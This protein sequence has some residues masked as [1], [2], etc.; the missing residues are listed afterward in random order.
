MI[1]PTKVDAR[2]LMKL[3]PLSSLPLRAL[4]MLAANLD[5][6]TVK[7]KTRIFEQ[8][9]TADKVFLLL[10][11]VVK[12]SWVNHYFHRVLVTPLG[13]GEFFGVGSLFSQG[14]HPY[15]C[16][17]VTDCL[18]GTASP[19]D[20]VGALMGISFPAFLRANDLLT[21]RVWNSYSRCIRGMGT[22]LRNR[23]ALELLDLGESFGVQDSRGTI[24]A[25]KTTHEDLADS[26]GFSRQKVTE[27]LAD[28]E[29]QGAIIREG[30]RLIL[31][32]EGLRKLLERG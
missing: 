3:K 28:F 11:G 21:S 5:V 16:E 26:I 29:K 17:T 9:Q 13:T 14:R 12:L 23:L 24:L 1:R 15:Q 30:R 27:A 20:V 7:C 25:V 32:L 19:E 4:E 6:Q 10:R 2:L 18:I 31:N 8:D 22:P